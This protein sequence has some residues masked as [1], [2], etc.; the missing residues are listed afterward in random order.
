MTTAIVL[1]TSEGDLGLALGFGLVLIGT[2]IAVSAS[3]FALWER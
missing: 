1:K 3:V 2:S